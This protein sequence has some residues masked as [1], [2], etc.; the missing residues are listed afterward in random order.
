MP[1]LAVASHCLDFSQLPL[2]ITVQMRAT[3]NA[4]ASATEIGIGRGRGRGIAASPSPSAAGCRARGT[5]LLQPAAAAAVEEEEEAFLLPR[6][7]LESLLREVSA[8]PALVPLP[9]LLAQAPFRL[10]RNGSGW[11]QRRKPLRALV[12][13]ASGLRWQA[14]QQAQQPLAVQ[15]G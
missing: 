14:G 15:Q 6:L 4:S 2:Q 11:K 9:L 13:R 3:C 8:V 5:M 7:Q 10:L 12:A 1:R